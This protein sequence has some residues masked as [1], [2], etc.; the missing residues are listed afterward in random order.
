MSASTWIILP[1]VTLALMSYYLLELL[2]AYICILVYILVRTSFW[3]GN[4][5]LYINFAA[6]MVIAFSVIYLLS[7]FNDARERKIYS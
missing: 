1:T 6:F 7:R 3:L 4:K 2:I 5:E